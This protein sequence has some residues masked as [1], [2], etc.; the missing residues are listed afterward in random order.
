MSWNYRLI[1]FQKRH[2]RVG[3]HSWYAVHEVYYRDD[4]SIKAVS[5]EPAAIVGD[6][7]QEANG[8]RVSMFA[9]FRA[10]PLDMDEV[11]KQ[12]KRERAKSKRAASRP[13][14]GPGGSE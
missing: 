6:T 1:R 4:G 5:T 8:T 7:V 2:K 9:A 14:V 13:S 3:E 12:W 10:A 11:K